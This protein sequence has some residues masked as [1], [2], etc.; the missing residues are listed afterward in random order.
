MSI[1]TFATRSLLAGLVLVV[2]LPGRALGAGAGLDVGVFGS[3][4]QR[5]NETGSVQKRDMSSWGLYGHAGLSPIPWLKIG[6]YGEYHS[7]NQ[8][9]TASSVGG[10]DLSG[11]GYLLGPAISLNFGPLFILGAYSLVGSYDLEN[12]TSSGLTSE[13]ASPEA[14]HVLVGFSVLPKLTLDVGYTRAEYK[15]VKQ[16]GA[17]I[18]ISANR[19]LWD[20][21]R[22]AL[23]VHF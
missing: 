3:L 18:D 15:E 4:G 8:R 19:R 1:R 14:Y 7:V 16:G 6:P 23:S 21:Y 2:F 12:R 13:L 10:T 11:D 17:T 20:S 22:V 5:Q 9:T